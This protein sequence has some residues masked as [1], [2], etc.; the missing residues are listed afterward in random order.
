[1]SET[2][3]TETEKKDSEIS[4][5][6]EKHTLEEIT[7]MFSPKKNTSKQEKAS[8]EAEEKRKMVATKDTVTSDKTCHLFND[9]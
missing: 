8:D 1:M 4:E 6:T 2:A 7:E 9:E 5:L 3:T